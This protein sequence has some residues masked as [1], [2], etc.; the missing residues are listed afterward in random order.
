[1]T[2]NSTYTLRAKAIVLGLGVNGLALAR[3]LGQKG[4]DVRGVYELDTDVGRF[5]RYVKAIQFLPLK[6]N[7]NR[8]LQKLIETFG[9]PME[10][11]VLIAQSD[12]YV[13]F[14][15]NNRKRLQEY[16]RFLIPEKELLESLISK[17]RASAY[18]SDKGLNV[19]KTYIFDNK[20]NF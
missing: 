18:A 14:M 15:S 7:D 20:E 17:D 16:F 2:H 6:D 13:D 8:F 19:P 4:V 11:P 9:D 10:K 1:M 12:S 5:S 3:S